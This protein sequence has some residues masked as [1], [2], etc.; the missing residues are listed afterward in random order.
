MHSIRAPWTRLTAV[1][2]HIDHA[3]GPAFVVLKMS[4]AMH[5]LEVLL[6]APIWGL[7]PWSEM[8]CST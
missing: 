3:V 1:G 8:F 7:W 5:V 2:S 4:D 6:L